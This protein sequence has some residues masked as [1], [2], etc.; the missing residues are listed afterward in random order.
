MIMTDER[1]FERIPAWQLRAG[2]VMWDP[3]GDLTVFNIRKANGEVIFDVT[4]PG[5]VARDWA[6][7]RNDIVRVYT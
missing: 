5:F 3:A 7:D 1:A 6:L 2:R 4:A